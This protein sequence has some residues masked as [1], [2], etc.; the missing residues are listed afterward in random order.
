MTPAPSRWP[1]WKVRPLIVGQ[2]ERKVVGQLHI[3]T[4]T[5]ARSC[6]F[7]PGDRPERFEK[8]WASAADEIILD[9]EDSVSAANKTVARL[10]ADKWLSSHRPA[11][12]RINGSE[13]PWYRKDLELLQNPGL[14]GILV[15]KAEKFENSLIQTCTALSKVLIPLI[16]TALGFRRA[17]ELADCPN[18][19]RLA[20]G[21]LDFQS[22]LGINDDGDALLYFRSELVLVSRLA[23]IAPPLDGVTV[24]VGSLKTVRADAL[25]SKLLGFGGKLCVH[26]RQVEIVNQVFS[27][28]KQELTWA[29]TVVGAFEEAQGAAIAIN[30][31]MIDRPIALQ[32][33]RI[34]EREALTEKRKR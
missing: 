21:H 23:G 25:R 1:A 18:V 4:Q 26:P 9:L 3:E 15:S 19:E 10:N 27:P 34:L 12:L 7:I 13:T 31:K 5:L 6:L 32:A 28:T 2:G 16:E 30:G 17:R 8:G 33:M 29:R 11:L 14:R 20:F 22:D 24:S